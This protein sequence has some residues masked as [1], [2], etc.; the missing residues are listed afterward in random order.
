M[1]KVFLIWYSK[2]IID[3]VLLYNEI[4]TE[5]IKD[6]VPSKKK[7]KMLINV[8]AR[9]LKTVVIPQELGRDL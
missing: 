7:K 2:V 5:N 9:S 6:M 3:R 8:F 1:L 4:H